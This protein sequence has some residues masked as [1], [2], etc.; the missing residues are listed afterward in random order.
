M[1]QRWWVYSWSRI[2]KWKRIYEKVAEELAS[3]L[4]KENN[5]S[6]RREVHLFPMEWLVSN[7]VG[8]LINQ[9]SD[10]N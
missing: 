10:L 2:Q 4:V 3:E 7:I 5:S 6:E 8:F 9:G 1:G